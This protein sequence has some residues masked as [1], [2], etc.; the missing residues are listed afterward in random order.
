MAAFIVFLLGLCA[1]S[2]LN[3]LSDRL[4]RGESIWWGRSHCD[5]C[6]KSLRWFELIPVVS[7]ILQRGRCLRCHKPLS[8]QYP[9]VELVTA[10]GFVSLYPHYANWIVFSALLVIFIS[11]LKYQIIPDSMVAVGVIGAVLT[12][13]HLLPALGSFAFIYILWALTRGRGMGFGDVKFAGLMGLF[14]GFPAVI[15]AFYVAFL[16]GAVLGVILIIAGKKGWKSHIAFGPF[17]VA[18]TW[19]AFVWGAP[20]VNWWRGML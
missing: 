20:I 1:G 13:P 16:T 7:Y 8:I 2:F 10:L 9:L 15:V 14:L 4:P 19:I 12:G 5:H 17:L 3:V 18:G 11:D 6:K